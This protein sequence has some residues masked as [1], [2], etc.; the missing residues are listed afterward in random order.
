M[1]HHWSDLADGLV[2][3]AGPLKLQQYPG[4][5]RWHLPIARERRTSYVKS[6]GEKF[7]A[8]AS[9]V[10]EH[11]FPRSRVW[12]TLNLDESFAVRSYARSYLFEFIELDVV[13]T[14]RTRFRDLTSKIEELGSKNPGVNVWFAVEP[15]SRLDSPDFPKLLTV[16]RQLIRDGKLTLVVCES[17]LT[18][19][20]GEELSVEIT[21]A[22][23]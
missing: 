3:P 16:L 13:I 14:D 6:F 8:A 10:W 23:D 18:L 21:I 9:R 5:S 20:D 22:T 17:D 15:F 4:I 19:P 12:L 11:R 1:L 7:E 2:K